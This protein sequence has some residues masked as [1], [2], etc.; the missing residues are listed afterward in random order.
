M[1]GWR[2]VARLEQRHAHAAVGP[3]DNANGGADG[4]RLRVQRRQAEVV[5]FIGETQQSRDHRVV[6]LR[7]EEVLLFHHLSRLLVHQRVAL[8]RRVGAVHA[9][10]LDDGARAVL[11]LHREAARERRGVGGE[12][13]VRAE[14]HDLRTAL[15][16]ARGVVEDQTPG[17]LGS[18]RAVAHAGQGGG[19]GDGLDAEVE[20]EE[21]AREG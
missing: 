7:G 2:V 21:R 9:S 13:G 8:E 3:E 11:H 18:D 1:L 12:D 16:R 4:P 15:Q 10:D 5:V 17:G 6:V 14:A 20:G 19:D